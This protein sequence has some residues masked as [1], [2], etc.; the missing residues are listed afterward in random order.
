MHFNI[1]VHEIIDCFVKICKRKN[2]I[3]DGENGGCSKWLCPYVVSIDR[4]A[5][6][7]KIFF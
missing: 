5:A 1:E 2:Y 3:L 7:S 4:A 6:I